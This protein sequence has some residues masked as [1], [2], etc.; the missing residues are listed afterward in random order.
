MLS[1]WWMLSS[2]AGL[3]KLYR[4]FGLLKCP[5]QLY[6]ISSRLIALIFGESSIDVLTKVF[7]MRIFSERASY[8]TFDESFLELLKTLF[9]LNTV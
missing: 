6:I 7:H 1:D 3:E 8:E 2:Q 5:G 4:G 9:L